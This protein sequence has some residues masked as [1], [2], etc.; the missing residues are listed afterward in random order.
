MTNATD[1][2]VLVVCWDGADWDMINPLLDGGELPNLA[3]FTQQGVMGDMV[4]TRPL[5]KS[6]V[7]NS[8]A[9][10]KYADKHCVF[11]THEICDFG[12]ASRPVTSDSRR[13]KAF[14]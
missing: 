7:Y 6:M 5:M 1:S 14:W 3:A 11:G 9:T 2:K 8:V 10:G 12:K 13:A 4:S